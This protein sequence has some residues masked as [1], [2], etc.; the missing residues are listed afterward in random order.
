[1]GTS[2]AALDTTWGQVTADLLLV[3]LVL[4]NAYMGWLHGTVRRVFAF[5]GVYLGAF[6]AT[7]VG[8][9]I[10]GLLQQHSLYANAWSFV[11]VFVIVVVTV[12]IIGQ[13]LYDRLQMV[14]V[15]MF[16][17]MVGSIG[18]AIVGLAEA[19]ILFLVAL[20]MA[21]VQGAG[22]ET[23]RGAA[24]GAIRS[25][26]LSGQAVRLEPQVRFAFKPALPGD[27]SGHLAQSLVVATP[28]T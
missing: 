3:I 20:A 1:M 11:G 15:V 21:G 4:V 25:S 27:F 17:R 28:P 14:A 24:A 5:G 26:T 12:E 23:G 13:V 2:L 9:A 7:N 19:L 8:N 18:G 16:D 10:A 22:A 6:A